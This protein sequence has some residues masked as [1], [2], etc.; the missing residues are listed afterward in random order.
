MYQNVLCPPIETVVVTVNK[1]PDIS[2]LLG[3]Y[4]LGQPVQHVEALGAAGGFS[5]A[6][7]WRVQTTTDQWCLRKWPRAHPS[8][9]RLEWIHAVLQHAWQEGF[10]RLPLPLAD[11]QGAVVAEQ[12]GFFWEITP[13]L[14]GDVI[15]RLPVATSQLSAAME[16]LAHFHQAVVSFPGTPRIAQPSPGLVDRYRLLQKMIDSG[17]DQIGRQ[18][19]STSHRDI[20]E[21]ATVI[22]ETSR[23]QAP[24]LI[25]QLER[26]TRI[27]LPWQPCIRDIH[28]QHVLFAGTRVSGLID[29]GAMNYDTIAT[30]VARLLGSLAQ[31]DPQARQQGLLAY[32]ACRPL[33]TTERDLVECFDQANV[34]LSPLNWLQWLIVDGR[35]FDDWSLVLQRLD[36]LIERFPGHP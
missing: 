21:R 25:S 2:G 18:L 13:W 29:F 11:S 33:T 5:G 9:D 10:T 34:V 22:L 28:R 23:R 7:F 20:A 27:N 8:R 32:Q 19:L 1:L 26:M 31:D 35:Q 30:D 14:S 12:E 36:E 16:T 4:D 24:S 3:R 17:L 6:E 15:E